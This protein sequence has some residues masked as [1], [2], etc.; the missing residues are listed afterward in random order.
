M[1]EALGVVSGAL[2]VVSLALQLVD[3]AQQ[4]HTFWQSFGESGSDVERIKDHLATLHAVA[5]TIADIC[6]Q[7]P[8]IQH[9]K[10]VINSLLACKSRTDKLAQLTRNIGVDREVGRWEKSW[11]NLR[12]TVKDKSIRKIEAQLNRDVM[13]LLLALQPFFQSVSL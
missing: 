7:E 3:A 13:M 10:S 12:A 5:A 2:A 6:Q 11:I 8:E 4:L 9:A 1:A